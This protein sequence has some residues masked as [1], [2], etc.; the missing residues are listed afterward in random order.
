M[1]KLDSRAD[2]SDSRASVAP[3]V[4]G[5]HFASF[6]RVGSR[7]EALAMFDDAY[8]TDGVAMIPM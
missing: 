1:N 3:H 5:V 7:Q 4:I 2:F 8:D 6:M